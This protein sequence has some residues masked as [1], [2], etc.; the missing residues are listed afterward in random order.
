M[1]ELCAQHC[2]DDI[3][4]TLGCLPKTLTETFDRA[5]LR[6]V[7]RRNISVAAKTFSWVAIAK[8]S[9]TLDELREAIS[10]DIGQPYSMPERLV[11]GIDQLA[12]WCE[13]LVHVDEELKTVQFA[14][15]AIHRFITEGPTGAQLESFRFDLPNADHHA[16]EIC[17]TYLHFNDFKTT[18]AR[19]PQPMQPVDPI[20][21]AKI[22][23]SHKLK[24][25]RTIPGLGLSSRRNK[26]KAQV[27]VVGVLS[28]YERGDEEESMQKLQQCHP[29][30]RY[31][32]VHWISHTRRFRQS[33]KTWNLWHRMITSGHALAKK[34]WPEQQV[35]DVL[36]P[37]VVDW[38]V[39][40]QHYALVR[41]A[42]DCGAII[43]PQ[44]EKLLSLA[45]ER[46]VELL[47]VLLEGGCSPEILRMPLW[48][49]SKAGHLAAVERLLAVGASVNAV[50]TDL[51]G[52][53]ALQA[54]SRGGHREVVE[55]LLAAGAKVNGHS[56]LDHVGG[57][58]LQEASGGG[59]LEV[60][61]Q[62]LA[63]G[64]DVNAAPASLGR[65]ALQ[66]ASKGGHLEIVERLLAA[67]ADVD[68]HYHKT[69]SEGTALQE[70]AK[71]GHLNVVERLIAAGADVNIGGSGNRGLTGYHG[72]TAIQAA[73]KA[74][75]LEI[76]ERLLAAEDAIRVRA[77]SF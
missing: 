24:L 47:D 77:N 57:T 45:A 76:V 63:A 30:L 51:V 22:A 26:S 53:T 44:R 23:L 38:G 37:K 25:P 2:D 29:F 72:L 75:H 32:T 69:V 66:A 27:D 15:Q 62:L 11:N 74:G 36:D 34:P 49:A 55:R 13:N 4:R 67:G 28:T 10:I 65:T 14:H 5:L 8:R 33:S 12:S 68:A 40:S 7:S 31:A 58:A 59:H 43:H 19:R 71:A 61:E 1:D 46:D 73:S 42:D 39:Q 21:M 50:S 16:G 54:A 35:S 3:R 6:I 56:A 48:D 17:V 41:L 64:A 60:V 70:A 18:L 9:L 52:Q 20:A